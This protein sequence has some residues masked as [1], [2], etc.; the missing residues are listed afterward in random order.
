L[1]EGPR[2]PLRLE[3]RRRPRW[4]QRLVNAWWF[5][6]GFVIGVPVFGAA[7]VGLLE[8]ASWAGWLPK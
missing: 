2:V 8:L 5:L 1:E 6:V 7:A 3:P 4:R